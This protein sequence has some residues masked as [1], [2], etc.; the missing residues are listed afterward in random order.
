[1]SL[2]IVE[3]VVFGPKNS[4]KSN[5]VNLLL[6]RG[7]F[8]DEYIQQKEDVKTSVHQLKLPNDE[9]VIPIHYKEYKHSITS[10]PNNPKIALFCFDLSYIESKVTEKINQHKKYYPLDTIF[11]VGTK[12][13]LYTQQSEKTI[14]YTLQ[15]DTNIST[16][17]FITSSKDREGIDALQEAIKATLPDVTNRIIQHR[18]DNI[19]SAIGYASKKLKTEINKL[20]KELDDCKTFH[21]K[22]QKLETITTKLSISARSELIE[23]LEDVD[24]VAKKIVIEALKKVQ[25]SKTELEFLTLSQELIDRCKCLFKGMS[26]LNRLLLTL[27]FCLAVSLIF[28]PLIVLPA[29]SLIP[30]VGLPGYVA[31]CAVGGCGLG[32]PTWVGAHLLF[33]KSTPQ[34]NATT[35][36]DKTLELNTQETITESW[37]KLE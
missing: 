29:M 23:T 34:Q 9:E 13:D 12:K 24:P 32:I 18:K 7:E 30:I 31:L 1:M 15:K 27:I 4:G 20:L 22:A 25:N 26:F 10:N 2:D 14:E 3:V 19:K 37:I 11:L 36:L 8:S 35:L 28:S 6:D 17:L 16:K 5:L 33:F 21:D